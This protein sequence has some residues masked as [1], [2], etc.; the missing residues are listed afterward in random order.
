MAG[1][2]HDV[3]AVG[4]GYERYMGRWSRKVAPEFLKLIAIPPQKSWLDVGCG[5]GAL[6]QAIVDAA[7]PNRVL[8]VD[9]SEGFVA[10]ARAHVTD[11]RA[12]FRKADA[13]ALPVG[14]SEF[15]AVV[16]A[17]VLNFIPDQAKAAGEMRRAA[18]DGGTV[19]AYVWDYAGEMQFLRRF[20]DAAAAL[21]PKAKELVEG[22][23]FP[24]CRPQ[25]LAD[26]FT[27]AGLRDVS[28]TAIDAPTV[29]RD[30][31]DYWSPFLGGQGPAAGY[32]M[33]L[34]EQDRIALR[35]RIR[36][37]LPTQRDGSIRLIAR[38]WAV[39]GTR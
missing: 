22:H 19:A 1:S 16:S 11:P 34:S 27:G 8:G 29:F 15:D 7:A 26:L 9:P 38:A 25:P 4:T 10:H 6:S 12:D 33:S 5:S 30:F 24:L 23:R 3:W 37:G 39:R 31:D 17:L 2:Q 36:G 35:E 20:W 28:V 13:Q 21:N 14:D 32:C 18:R